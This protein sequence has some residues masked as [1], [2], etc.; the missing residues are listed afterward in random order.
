VQFVGIGSGYLVDESA[1]GAFVSDVDR[2]ISAALTQC[3][4]EP[5]HAVMVRLLLRRLACVVSAVFVVTGLGLPAPAAG[6]EAA[7]DFLG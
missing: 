4:R 7:Q 1:F 5:I 3:E 2:Q 6:S